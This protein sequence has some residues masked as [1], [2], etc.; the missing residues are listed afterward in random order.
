MKKS[1]LCFLLLL[2]TILSFSQKEKILKFNS[3]LMNDYSIKTEISIILYYQNKNV[4][5][6]SIGEVT[7]FSN[8]V[9]EPVEEEWNGIKILTY[10]LTDQNNSLTNLLYLSS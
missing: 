6:G 1:T 8:I 7:S 4:M 9:G 3:L 10:T 2:F 5:K